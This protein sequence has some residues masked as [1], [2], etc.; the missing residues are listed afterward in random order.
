MINRLPNHLKRHAIAYIAVVALLVA[1]G[2]S[3]YAAVEIP[4]LGATHQTAKSGIT[5]TGSCPATKV[6]WAYIGVNGGPGALPG[7]P[8]NVYQTPVGGVPV[9][10][11]HQGLGDWLV[12]FESQDL[13]NCARFA[14]LVHDRGSA[15]VA[16]FDHLNPDPQAIHVLTTDAHGNPADLDFDV[17]AFCGNSKGLQTEPAPPAAGTH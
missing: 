16:G 4:Q 8:P 1:L 17:I 5:C 14:N 15:T 9:H 7:S 2:G 12:Y 6:F 11:T 3:S 13:T 10:L